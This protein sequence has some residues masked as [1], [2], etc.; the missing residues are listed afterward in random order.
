MYQMERQLPT[1]TPTYAYLEK[2]LFQQ[3]NITLKNGKRRSD[4]TD[5][6]IIFI[7]KQNSVMQDAHQ[8]LQVTQS[9]SDEYMG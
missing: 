5:K 7:M 1:S 8:F 4:A 9:G 3:C 2:H 6:N